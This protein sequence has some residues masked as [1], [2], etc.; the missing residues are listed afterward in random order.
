MGRLGSVAEERGAGR[1]MFEKDDAPPR[2]RGIVA[3]EGSLDQAGV[4]SGWG[5]SDKGVCNRCL[6]QLSVLPW[7]RSFRDRSA[8]RCGMITV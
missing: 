3:L 6:N 1:V 7:R 4:P 5:L 8:E 2:A